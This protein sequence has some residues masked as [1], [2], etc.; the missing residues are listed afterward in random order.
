MP[1]S[2]IRHFDYDAAA[3]RLDIEFVSG[4]RYSYHEV[5]P[6]VVEAMRR[7]TSRAASSTAASATAS[8][9]RGRW[10]PSLYSPTRQS[11]QPLAGG[12]RLTQKVD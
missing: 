9:S 2:V 12:S 4:R 7:A 3:H 11:R 8:A 10:R 1:S 6:T 5:P